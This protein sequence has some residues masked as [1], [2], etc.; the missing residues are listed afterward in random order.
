MPLSPPP[1]AVIDTGPLFT[2]LT[3]SFLQK[4]PELAHIREKHEIPN[5]LLDP[6]SQREFLDYIQNIPH[7][8]TTSHVIGQLR[9]RKQLTA[10]IQAEF[11]QNAVDFFAE[12][13][14]DERCITLLEISQNGYPKIIGALGPTDAG[15]IFLARQESCDLLTDDGRMGQWLG[16]DGKSYIKLIYE[17]FNPKK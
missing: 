16:K 14:L 2:A 12:K 11:W 9:S 13:K 15:L 17:L 3:L 1:K 4:R 7:L 5:Y 8:M 10:D 6:T